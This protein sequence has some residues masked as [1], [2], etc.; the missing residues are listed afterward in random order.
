MLAKQD[1]IRD[2][3]L[4]EHRKQV[5]SGEYRRR[6]HTKRESGIFTGEAEAALLRAFEVDEAFM[7]SH[8]LAFGKNFPGV[9]E[10]LIYFLADA[11]RENLKSDAAVEILNKQ[12]ESIYSFG[13]ENGA[14]E[15]TIGTHSLMSKDSAKKS[16]DG[17][18]KQVLRDEAMALAKF[19]SATLAILMVRRVQQNPNPE[20]GYDW[21]II[22][23]HFVR[24]PQN[25]HSMTG[26]WEG[27]V[28]DAAATGG[29]LPMLENIKD[30]PPLVVLTTNDPSNRLQNLC[31]GTTIQ[32][33]EKLYKQMEY[34]SQ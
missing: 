33:L 8:P 29:Q 1:N 32:Q 23:R 2:K 31:R 3:R 17:T 12:P 21:E 22:V 20:Q 19:V 18:S 11:Q 5:L 13:T 15:E 10:F 28:L 25:R 27:E 4:E 7:R 30:K 6:I 24:F 16:K 9:G 26:T 34:R 14:S